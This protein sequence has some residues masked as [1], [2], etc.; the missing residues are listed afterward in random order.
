MD[1]NNR[2]FHEIRQSS[3]E[4]ND[5]IFTLPDDQKVKIP[6]TDGHERIYGDFTL[7]CDSFQNSVSTIETELT[8]VK[9]NV[10]LS[11]GILK[12]P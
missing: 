11:G 12:I 7:L 6:A 4:E 5:I 10:T 8:E 3:V 1:S 9:S 2:K